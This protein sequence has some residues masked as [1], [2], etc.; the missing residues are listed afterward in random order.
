MSLVRLFVIYPS[1]FRQLIVTLLNVQYFNNVINKFINVYIISYSNVCTSA[2][3]VQLSPTIPILHQ[4]LTYNEL[5]DD[6]C[7]LYAS[8]I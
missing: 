7:K 8:M 3:F 1:V 6:I 4:S 2:G 5:G